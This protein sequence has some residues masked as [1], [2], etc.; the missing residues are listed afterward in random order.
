MGLS[1]TK[2]SPTGGSAVRVSFRLA[3]ADRQSTVLAE[4]NQLRP[5]FMVLLGKAL[6]VSQCNWESAGSKRRLRHRDQSPLPVVS[7]CSTSQ[8]RLEEQ[9]QHNPRVAD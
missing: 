8:S 4:R 9:K 5:N 6:P 2:A 3:R 7:R 1:R